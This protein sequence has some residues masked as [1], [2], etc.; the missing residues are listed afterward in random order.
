MSKSLRQKRIGHMQE[1]IN[2]VF[3]DIGVTG[4]ANRT[5]CRADVDRFRRERKI[6]HR[7]GRGLRRAMRQQAPRGIRR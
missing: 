7:M 1:L 6:E 3:K 4:R 5:E 2:W